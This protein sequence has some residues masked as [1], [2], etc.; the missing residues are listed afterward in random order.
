MYLPEFIIDGMYIENFYRVPTFLYESVWCLIGV[1]ILWRIRKKYSNQVGRQISFYLIWY[2]IGRFFIE[3]FRS[4]SLYLGDFRIS[5]LISI[6]FVLIGVIGM[7]VSSKK[8]KVQQ[9]EVVGNDGRI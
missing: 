3:G 6:G 9:I 7:F 4:D 8:S 2:G 5:Q 1:V